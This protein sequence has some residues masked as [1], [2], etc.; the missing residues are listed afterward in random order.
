MK[1]V[2][3]D[4]DEKRGYVRITDESLLIIVESLSTILNLKSVNEWSTK[5]NVPYM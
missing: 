4:R 3:L 5:V 1:E 2:F